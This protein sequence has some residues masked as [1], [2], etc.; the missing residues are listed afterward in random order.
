M[1]RL[2][3]ALLCFSSLL[4][5]ANFKLYLK[6][7]NYHVVREY[8]VEDDRV[9]Y[10]SIERSDWEEMPVSLVD[11]KRTEGEK[12][13]RAAAVSEE[14]KMI[15][16]E[17]KAVKEEHAT[18]SKIPQD[19]G[20][21]SIGDDGKLRIFPLAE[22]KA[23]TN[24]GRSVLKVLSP[25]PL[26]PGKA[27]VEIDGEHSPNLIHS[28][29]QEFYIQTATD[30]RFTIIKLATHKG[31]R[32]AERL[33]IIPVTK[34]VEEEVDEVEIFRKQLTQSGLFKIWPQKALEPGEYAV[35]EYT[36]G[37]LNAQMWDFAFK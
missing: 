25:V 19:P 32:V 4:T 6:D 20:V 29:S 22:S 11:L 9:R 30:E 35:I 10:Y 1:G 8:K 26:V 27:T 37:K 7:G 33:T 15:E 2:L 14:S 3:S 13:D 28:A 34:E 12:A 21:Y 36:A 16:E 31:L 18:I 23:H 24:K 5:A 17:D